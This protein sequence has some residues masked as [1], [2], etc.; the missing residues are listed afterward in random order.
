MCS[1]EKPIFRNTFV[2]ITGEEFHNKEEKRFFEK[3]LIDNFFWCENRT[4]FKIIIV[5]QPE[6]KALEEIKEV[7]EQFVV[8]FIRGVKEEQILYFKNNFFKDKDCV[9]FCQ[10]NHNLENEK[11]INFTK[12]ADY[13]V[14]T[15]KLAKPHK[16]Y[17]HQEE[18]PEKI[19][20]LYPEPPR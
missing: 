1:T 18:M 17:F 14:T 4:K 6:D 15:E 3:K 10:D 5:H 20:K 7:E 16:T 9:M 8:L 2:F 11:I 19:K 13:F 12:H